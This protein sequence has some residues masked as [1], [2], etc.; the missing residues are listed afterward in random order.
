MS[1][2]I[3]RACMN[4]LLRQALHRTRGMTHFI[5]NPFTHSVPNRHFCKKKSLERLFQAGTTAGFVSFLELRHVFI[6]P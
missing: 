3:P 6:I 4:G 5:F 2:L 1:T